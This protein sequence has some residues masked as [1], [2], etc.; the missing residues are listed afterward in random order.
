[1][2]KSVFEASQEVRKAN[3]KTG[4]FTQGN[5]LNA[6]VQ[7]RQHAPANVEVVGQVNQGLEIVVAGQALTFYHN[8]F[9]AD[10]LDLLYVVE[11]TNGRNQS[12]L[13]EAALKPL[14]LAIERRGQIYPGVGL[15][16]ADGRI[17]VLDG[18][19]RLK[20]AKGRK[21]SFLCLVADVSSCEDSLSNE[22]KAELRRD[23]QTAVEPSL[24]ELGL[25]CLHL[26]KTLGSG[27]AVA[28]HL[29]VSEATVSR[30]K[31]AAAIPMELMVLFDDF[32]QLS[33]PEYT[34]LWK[35]YVADASET[36]DFKGL[37][38]EV[39]S[40]LANQDFKDAADQKAAVLKSLKSS[41]VKSAGGKASKVVSEP[42]FNSN[43]NWRGKKKSKPTGRNGYLNVV[44]DLSRVPASVVSQID[45]LLKQI[46]DKSE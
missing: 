19:R 35:L 27:K 39:E 14:T 40:S 43:S 6:L 8:I 1:M 42:L 25:E 28:E 12:L 17:E 41:A 16:H 32:N 26:E 46:S 44:Y 9:S 23:L 5:N 3:A 7:A 21:T 24:Y 33:H 31:K 30:A 18:S 45:E 20:V 37:A 11:E 22:S 2:P 34:A 29:A 15:K 10:Q 13:T 4:G 38:D 36:M